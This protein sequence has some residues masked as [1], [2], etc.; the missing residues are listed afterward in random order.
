MLKSILMDAQLGLEIPILKHYRESPGAARIPVLKL[1][2]YL[3][4]HST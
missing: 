4:S 2:V 3:F 1:Y